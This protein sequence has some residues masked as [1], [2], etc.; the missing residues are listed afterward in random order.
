M[1]PTGLEHHASFL[2]RSPGLMARLGDR[3]YALYMVGGPGMASG[4][5]LP[6]D[7]DD[8]WV[9]AAMGPQPVLDGLLASPDAAIGAIRA[10]AGIP[11][12]EVE[13]LASMPLEFAAQLAP[14]GASGARSSPATPPTGCR[15]S[16]AGA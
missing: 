5:L 9:Y 14:R 11:D 10:A 16:A 15:R 12:L 4:V 8:R 7:R 13:L 1:G 2:F 3:R 6:M